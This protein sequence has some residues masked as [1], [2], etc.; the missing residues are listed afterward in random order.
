M[1]FATSSG[2]IELSTRGFK[3]HSLELNKRG[4]KMHWQWMM[5]DRAWQMTL[6]SS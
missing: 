2:A 5:T 4:L 1:M 3:M 6:A